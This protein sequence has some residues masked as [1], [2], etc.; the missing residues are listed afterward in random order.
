MQEADIYCLGAALFAA[1]VALASMDTFWFLEVREGWEWLADALTFIWIA[2]AM[3]IVAWVKVR[4][5]E[6]HI[7]FHSLSLRLLALD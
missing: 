3:S 2:V 4:N 7:S 5:P 6:S 1:F